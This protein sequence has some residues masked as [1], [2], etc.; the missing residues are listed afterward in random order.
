FQD[1]LG[2]LQFFDPACGCGNFLIIAYRELRLLEIEVIRELVEYQR[3]EFGQFMGHLDVSSLSKINVDQF[4]GIEISEFPAR[5]AETGMWMID[6][7]MNNH[8]SY[9]FGQSYARIPL[10]KFPHITVGN[11]LALDWASVLPPE[12]CSHVFRNP[13]F[14]GHQYRTTEQQQD[15]ARVWGREGQFNRLDY[16]SCWHKRSRRVFRKQQGNRHR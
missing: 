5:I 7:M 9:E 2:E 12:R 13:P 8:L 4:F 15:M 10:T 14:R 16:V 6:H 1:R 3:D 11:A